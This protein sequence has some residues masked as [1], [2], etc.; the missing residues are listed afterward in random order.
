[1][2]GHAHFRFKTPSRD[3]AILHRVTLEVTLL[4]RRFDLLQ[5]AQCT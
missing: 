1:M 2:R 4:T 5:S 3:I